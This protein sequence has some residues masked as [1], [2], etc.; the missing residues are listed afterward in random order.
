MD[1]VINNINLIDVINEVIDR[2]NVGIKGSII[3]QIS[4]KPLQGNIIIDDTNKYLAP[5]FFDAHFHV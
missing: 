1:I 5:A 4:D 3:T 2:V